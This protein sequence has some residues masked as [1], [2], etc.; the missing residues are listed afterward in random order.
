MDKIQIKPVT[1][2]DRLWTGNFLAEHRGS[3]QVIAK[4]KTSRADELPGFIAQQGEQFLGLITYRIENYECEIVTLNSSI[5]GLGVGTEL[6]KMAIQAAVEK[7]C[8]RVWAIVTNDNLNALR[9]F[10]TRGFR[11]AELYRNAVDITREEHPEIPTHGFD[12]I[13]IRDEIEVEIKLD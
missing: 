10:Q 3:V 5:E 8:K 7:T 12:S 6:L 13:P 9:F 1:E 2:Q 4:G 11:L